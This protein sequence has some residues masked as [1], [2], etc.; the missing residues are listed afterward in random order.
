MSRE[1]IRNRKADHYHRRATHE[2][3][4]SRAAYKL[5]EID[6]RIGMLKIGSRVLDV[7][8]S[9]G[10]WSQ[11]AKE[12]VGDGIV[13]AVDLGDMPPIDGV[14][15]IRGDISER[16][17]ID[18][19]KDICQ[20]FDVV[21]SDASPRLSGNKVYD[22]GR[23]LALCWSV[24]ELAQEMLRPGGTTVI[25]MFQGDELIE[26]REHFSIMY[27]SVDT[28][29]PRSSLNRSSEVYLAFRRLLRDH[30]APGA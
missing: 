7:G 4:R 20:E 2:G 23:D 10:G 24:M 15:F 3:Y 13:V 18:R 27:R 29:K 25:K 30:P 11:V 9:P 14:S 26:L 28:L 1:W 21:L 17:T 19:I 6:D 22:R 16:A 8:A 12:R 5:K